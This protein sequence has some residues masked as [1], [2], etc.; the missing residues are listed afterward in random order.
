MREDGQPFHPEH[1]SDAFERHVRRTGLRRIRLHD[2]RHTAATLS[3]Q[4]GIPTKVVSE[5]LGHA[6]IAITDDLYR[7]AIPSM[8][9]EAGRRLTDLILG[10]DDQAG[11]DGAP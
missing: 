8:P 10:T 1:F 3:L 7:H 9:E 4:A 6:S 11:L 5:W 2:T